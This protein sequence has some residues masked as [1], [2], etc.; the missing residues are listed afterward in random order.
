V[1]VCVGA[2]ARAGCKLKG[3]FRWSSFVASFTCKTRFQETDSEWLFHVLHQAL[4]VFPLKVIQIH[5]FRNFLSVWTKNSVHVWASLIF[6]SKIPPPCLCSNTLIVWCFIQSACFVIHSTTIFDCMHRDCL[7]Y[8]LFVVLAVSYITGQSLV[9]Q[10]QKL[11]YVLGA[12]FICSACFFLHHGK[13]FG[14]RE[15]VP[16]LSASLCEWKDS[17]HLFS[18]SQ[19]QIRK[20]RHDVMHLGTASKLHCCRSAVFCSVPFFCENDLNTQ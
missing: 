17:T 11:D 6:S 18:V 5:V 8:A 10:R 4:Q 20:F 9:V 2:R 1:C 15:T 12:F 13:I 16:A 19:M 7:S 14:C 3:A